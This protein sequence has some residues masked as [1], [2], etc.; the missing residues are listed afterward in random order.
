[1]NINGN[2]LWPNAQF[3]LNGNNL[4][5]GNLEEEEEEEKEKEKEEKENIKELENIFPFSARSPLREENI[6]PEKNDRNDSFKVNSINKRERRRK[7][8]REMR[9]DNMIGR[10]QNHFLIFLI[11]FCNDALKTEYKHSLYHFFHINYTHRAC[12]RRNYFSKFTKS[13]IKDILNF[14]I[15]PKYSRYDK[16]ENKKLLEK[17]IPSSEWLNHLFE[18]NYLDLFKSYYN[19]EKPLNKIY[20]ENKLIVFS[21]NTKS[22]YF[23]LEKYKDKDFKQ[24]IIDIAKRYYL[25]END[26]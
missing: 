6:R 8:M 26:D 14:E 1:M 11:N 23:L 25:N 20:F 9:D 13:K 10:I 3:F 7:K 18:M 15:S 5:E 16:S 12:F 22:F 19:K 2:T 24:D 21:P 4:K 17:I